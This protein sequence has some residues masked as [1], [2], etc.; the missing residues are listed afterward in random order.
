MDL[1]LALKLR[2][3]RKHGSAINQHALNARSFRDQGRIGGPSTIF[4]VDPE[5]PFVGSA[6]PLIRIDRARLFRPAIVVRLYHTAT[7]RS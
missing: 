7:Q 6:A 3:L 2:K 4:A 1:V 5:P